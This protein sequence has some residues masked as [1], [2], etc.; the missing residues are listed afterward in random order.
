MSDEALG[1]VVSLWRYPVKSMMGEELNACD[2]SERGLCG[3][4]AYGLVDQETGK[5]ASAKHPR[6]WGRLFD[7][8]ADFVVPPTLDAPAPP[9]RIT[10]PRGASVTSDEPDASRRLSEALGRPVALLASAPTGSSFEEVWPAVKGGRLYGTVLPDRED[11]NLVTD[12]PAAFRAPG[13]TFFDFCAVHLVTTN[14]LDRLRELAPAHR[15]EAR[16]FR[17]NF[18]VDVPHRRGFVENDWSRRIV[19]VGEVRLKIIIPTARCVM[20]TLAQGDLPH[21]PGVLRAMAEHNRIRA[22]GLGEL[23]C[24]G[25][26]A[27]VLTPGT[28][29]RGDPVHV[30]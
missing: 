28:V 9:V 20:T 13:G 26:Y 6:K 7:F 15:F 25:M 22:G 23:P 3:D 30:E 11:E 10:F 24:A 12:V 18:V 4:R 16:R 29:R 2:V 14:T 1:T 27:F 8:R 5:L 21:D 17:P 19:I